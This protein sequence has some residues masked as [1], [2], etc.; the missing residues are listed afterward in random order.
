MLLSLL[1][2]T[3]WV[4]VRVKRALKLATVESMAKEPFLRQPSDEDG[5]RRPLL[6][7]HDVLLRLHK[8]GCVDPFGQ[9][10]NLN[11]HRRSMVCLAT[12]DL[13]ID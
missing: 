8:A 9:L 7:L 11:A 4:L 6:E 13:A 2:V 5:I 12:A 1:R 10:F 3:F